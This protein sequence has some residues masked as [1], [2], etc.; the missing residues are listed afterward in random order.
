MDDAFS[1]LG[2]RY[3]RCKSIVV[4]KSLIGLALNTSD[5]GIGFPDTDKEQPFRRLAFKHRKS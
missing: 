1:L 3:G 4:V 2:R 5:E